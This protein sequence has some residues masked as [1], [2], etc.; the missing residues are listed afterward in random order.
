[1]HASFNLNIDAKIIFY[2][3]NNLNIY[4]QNIICYIYNFKYMAG[5]SGQM[6][7]IQEIRTQTL[8][9]S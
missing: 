1:M 8:H 5:K 3:K 9:D 6:L 2:G 7:I 4:M